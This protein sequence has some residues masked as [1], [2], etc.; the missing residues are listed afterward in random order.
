[1]AAA[2]PNQTFFPP[3][4]SSN[5][6][7]TLKFNS[8]QKFFLL[9]LACSSLAFFRLVFILC[10]FVRLYIQG[11]GKTTL[12]VVAPVVIIYASL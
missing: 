8:C 3:S 5:R 9:S 11:N 4:A 10:I 12:N 7:R 6:R 2:Y 1:V